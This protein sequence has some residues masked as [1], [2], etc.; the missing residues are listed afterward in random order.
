MNVA[1][2]SGLIKSSI[3]QDDE[4]EG[5]LTI[6]DEAIRMQNVRSEVLEK[7]VEFCKH[8]TLQADDRM[9]EIKVPLKSE[10]LED[11]VSEW[12]CKFCDVSFDMLQDLVCFVLLSYAVVRWILFFDDSFSPYHPVF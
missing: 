5:D 12:Y 10:Q 1:E 3:R 8:Y 7:V 4:D 9:D 6:P 11:I 2:M